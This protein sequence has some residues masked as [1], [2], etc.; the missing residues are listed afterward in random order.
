MEPSREEAVLSSR[1][2]RIPCLSGGEGRGNDL[3]VK[4]AGFMTRDKQGRGRE[5]KLELYRATLPLS[6]IL[7][8]PTLPFS[9]SSYVRSNLPRSNDT[10]PVRPPLYNSRKGESFGNEWNLFSGPNRF[11]NWIGT[12]SRKKKKGKDSGRWFE[13]SSME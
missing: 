8:S 10:R 3:R 2:V 12:F 4:L 1:L 6:I 9:S 11:V 5:G 7:F 13:K